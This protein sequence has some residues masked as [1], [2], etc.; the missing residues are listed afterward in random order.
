MIY[1]IDQRLLSLQSYRE[2]LIKNNCTYFFIMLPYGHDTTVLLLYFSSKAAEALEK[3]A[4][5]G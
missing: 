5:Y 4:Q 3:A 1:K 2:N